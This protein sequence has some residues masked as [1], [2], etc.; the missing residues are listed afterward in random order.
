V[1]DFHLKLPNYEGPLDVLLRLIEERQ[2]D[3]TVLSLA[4]VADQFIA[5]MKS[6]LNQNANVMSYFLWVASRL[7]VLKSRA[8]LPILNPPSPE[9]DEITDEEDLIAQL[10]AYQLYKHVAKML[11]ER[12]AMNLRSFPI[13]PPPI[14][15]PK[16]RSLSLDLDNVTLESLAKAM[17]RVVERCQPMP[18]ANE[19][20]A[21]LPF[22]VND[23][24]LRIET[25]LT[26]RRPV[27]FTD[28]LIGIN[29]RVEMVITLLALLE[30]LKRNTVSVQQNTVFGDIFIETAQP[31]P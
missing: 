16:S 29:T 2:L 9:A 12:S 22:T 13:S 23:C 15:R 14:E 6:M 5:H 30:L 27:R 1:S 20:I 17:Q 11:A 31:T 28:I 18:P 19:V 10:R 7:L 25:A 4:S 21:P 26:A 3:I 8:L 24:I